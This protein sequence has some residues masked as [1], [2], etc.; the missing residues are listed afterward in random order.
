[1]RTKPIDVNE[2]KYSIDSFFIAA[3][4]TTISYKNGFGY[5]RREQKLEQRE[6]TY[7]QTKPIDV[8]EQK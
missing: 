8:N 5:T 4:L 7:E 1:L 2:Q 3:L 6:R